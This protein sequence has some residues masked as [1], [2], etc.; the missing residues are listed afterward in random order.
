MSAVAEV[1]PAVALRVLVQATDPARREVLRQLV[2]DAGH[3]PVDSP[4][5]ADVV[6]SDQIHSVLGAQATGRFGPMP[7][8]G[9]QVLFTP[10]ELE[11]LNAIG[12]GLTNKMIARRL[13]ISPHTVK[14]HVESL[15]R[16]LGA[17]TRAEAVAKAREHRASNTV[18]L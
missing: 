1:A 7:E 8:S 5:V 2:I 17:R 15:L 11:V 16:K 18:E 9:G 4:S 6:L 13:D 10:R 12:D 14:F 3:L